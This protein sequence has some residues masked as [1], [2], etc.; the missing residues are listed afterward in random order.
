[1]PLNRS[2]IVVRQPSPARL[3]TVLGVWAHPDDEAYLSA[4]LMAGAWAAGNRVVAITATL[5][6]QGTGALRTSHPSNGSRK[7][8]RL[9]IEERVALPAS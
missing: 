8:S 7:P 1:V 2:D 9:T 4:G 5:G 3:D 6:E